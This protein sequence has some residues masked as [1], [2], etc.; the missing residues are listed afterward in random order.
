MK[1]KVLVVGAGRR[2]KGCQA[3]IGLAEKSV[4]VSVCG[5]LAGNSLFMK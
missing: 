3:E 4:S 2:L 1:D 5:T